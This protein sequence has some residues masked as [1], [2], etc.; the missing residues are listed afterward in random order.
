MVTGPSGQVP[1]TLQA[2]GT[3]NQVGVGSSAGV[4]LAIGPN[5]EMQ[6]L[7]DSQTFAISACAGAAGSTF[8]NLIVG[9]GPTSGLA[10]FSVN[11]T[12]QI[13]TNTPYLVI[14]DSQASV[15]PGFGPFS[16][17]AISDPT[18]TL[19]SDIGSAYSLVYSPGLLEADSVSPAPE[20]STFGLF[21]T[22]CVFGAICLLRRRLNN[23]PHFG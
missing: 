1:L 23:N 6:F 10:S 5:V 19:P 17:N 7:L 11:E 21:G 2:T 16:A 3:A 9:C 13:L 4:D 22:G 20:P 12:L 18:F 8:A 15:A 14:L